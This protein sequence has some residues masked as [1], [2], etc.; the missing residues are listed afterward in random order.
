MA[1]DR[2]PPD[3]RREEVAGV[4]DAKTSPK[5]DE[6]SAVR[7]SPAASKSQAQG[8]PREERKARAKEREERRDSAR[9]R[10]DRER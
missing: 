2:R 9:P 5:A 10:Q 1:R 8:R 4:M 7:L 6:P 3:G